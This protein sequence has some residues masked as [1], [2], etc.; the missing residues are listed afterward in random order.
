MHTL[1]AY[2]FNSL[3]YSFCEHIF[4]ISCNGTPNTIQNA[5]NKMTQ[6]EFTYRSSLVDE[7]DIEKQDTG[8]VSFS[9]NFDQT[10]DNDDFKKVCYG[11]AMDEVV[12]ILAEKYGP[13]TYNDFPDLSIRISGLTIT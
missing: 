9:V 11:V 3:T 13:S 8:I 10:V 2:Y 7:T 1:T 12:S 5:P 6:L 4:R